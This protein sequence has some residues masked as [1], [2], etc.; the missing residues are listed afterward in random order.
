LYGSFTLRIS[1][2]SCAVDSSHP[3]RNPARPHAFENV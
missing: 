2:Q 1:A 3:M